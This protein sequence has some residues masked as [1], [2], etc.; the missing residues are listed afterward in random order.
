MVSFLLAVK[1]YSTNTFS[2]RQTIMENRLKQAT[3]PYL[4]AHADKP[5]H[6]H[7]TWSPAAFAEARERD[8][9]IFLS[10]G[11]S[12]CHWCHTRLWNMEIHSD[13]KDFASSINQSNPL[14]RVNRGDLLCPFAFLSH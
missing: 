4:R 6:W 10:S 13:F 3:S 9:P 14:C 7:T 5:I 11:Y 12:S 8:V 2:R 1:R